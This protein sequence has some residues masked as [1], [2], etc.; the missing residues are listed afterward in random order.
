MVFECLQYG[1][2]KYGKWAR[3]I[4][5]FGEFCNI[6]T[7]Y[8]IKSEQDLTPKQIYKVKHI[9]I[10]QKRNGSLSFILEI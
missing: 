9:D 7:I 3:G 1:S 5:R 10:V 2:M 6:K 8:E 4:F